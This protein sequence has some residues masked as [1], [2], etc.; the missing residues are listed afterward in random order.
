MWDP[1]MYVKAIVNLPEC[2]DALTDRLDAIPWREGE[3]VLDYGCGT[4]RATVPF[5]LP[6]TVATNSRLFGVDK[7][8]AMITTANEGNK[9][10]HASYAVGNILEDGGFPHEGVIF[11]KIFSFYCLHWCKEYKKILAKFY[12]ILKPGGYICLLY[13][14]ECPHFLLLQQIGKL[15]KWAGYMKEIRDHFPDWI[16]HSQ[17]AR[18]E[19]EKSCKEIGYEKLESLVHKSNVKLT[20]DA[21]TDLVMS[22][23][24]YLSEIPSALYP[25]LKADYAKLILDKGDVVQDGCQELQFKHDMLFAIFRKPGN[26]NNGFVR[27]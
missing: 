24:P 10:D 11:D 17:D 1:D 26:E 2:L 22:L 4:G 5:L 19:L 20:L 6:K 3:V 18:T 15:P 21:F 25:E 12:S 27:N 9:S 23:N 14:I 7:S 13:V 8:S 16:E